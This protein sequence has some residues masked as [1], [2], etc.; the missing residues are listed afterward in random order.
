[1]AFIVDRMKMDNFFRKKMDNYFPMKISNYLR[2]LLVRGTSL[3]FKSLIKE[4][5]HVLINSGLTAVGNAGG[6]FMFR[7]YYQHGGNRKW[8]SASAK[9]FGFPVLLVPIS[10]LY[11]FQHRRSST[12]DKFLASPKVLLCGIGVGVLNGLDNFMHSLGF[13]ILP[14]STSSLLF[15]A[16]LPFTAIFALILVRHKFTPYSINSVVVITMGSIPLGLNKNSDTDC[17]TSPKY[18]L[19]F[20]A[21]LGAACLIGFILSCSEF[22]F[23]R[24]AKRLSYS[25]V[26]Q[27]QFCA[28]LSS[29]LFCTVGMLINKDFTAMATEARNFGLGATKYYL[30]LACN[31]VLWQL[32]LTGS[33]GLIFNSSAVSTGIFTSTLRPVIDTAAVIMD[34]EKFTGEKGMA[35]AHYAWGFASHLYG[36]FKNRLMQRVDQIG[37]NLLPNKQSGLAR[38]YYNDRKGLGDLQSNGSRLIDKLT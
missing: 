25:N 32:S 10:V 29:S 4:K 5:W 14:I 1:M 19:G 31:A 12:F 9:A 11:L 18:L 35:L 33:N 36:S 21:T 28:G 8:I 37:S 16:Q 7:L 27:F 26:L 23:K 13:S 3:P 30:V 20:V 6:T 22:T 34:H 15:A 2:M 17:V 24:V 38:L